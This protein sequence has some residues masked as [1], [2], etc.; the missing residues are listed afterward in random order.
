MEESSKTNKPKVSIIMRTKNSDWVVHQALKSLYS[1]TFREFELIIVDSGSTDKTLD[2]IK[3]YDC[4]VIKIEASAYYPG[5]VLNMAIKEAKSNLIIF[6]NS[7]SVMLTPKTLEKLIDAF[8]SYDVVLARQLPRPEAHSW[9]RRDYDISFP[10]SDKTPPWITLSL[11]L[12][13]FKKSL[14]EKHNFYSDAW[15]SEDT[16]WGNWAVENGIEIKYLKESITMHSHNYTLK[17]IYGRRFVEGE[18]DIFIYKKFDNIFKMSYRVVKSILS[19]IKYHIKVFDLKGLILAFP[20]RFVYQY[21]Y[22]KGQ[23]LGE[24]RWLS[25][26]GDTSCGQINVLSRY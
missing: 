23:K 6:Q 19:D 7:D 5:L 16:E 22:Y 18:A 12:A 24:K 13:G 8:N 17:Q 4:R 11:P 9:V 1:Q 25:G 2:I 14:W 20:R 15:A 3:N 21:A 26:D 10:N